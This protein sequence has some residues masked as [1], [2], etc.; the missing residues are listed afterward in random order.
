ME[1]RIS[2]EIM[3]LLRS[4]AMKESQGGKSEAERGAMDQE[5]RSCIW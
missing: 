2:A 1:S 5:G 3:L 4:V